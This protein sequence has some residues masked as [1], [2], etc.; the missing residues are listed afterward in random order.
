MTKPMMFA[1]CDL[2]PERWA[3]EAQ[4]SSRELEEPVSHGSDFRGV[5]V[6]AL[7]SVTASVVSAAMAGE[8]TGRD[9]MLGIVCLMARHCGRLVGARVASK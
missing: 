4:D 6:F 5:D 7:V 2:P 3:A 1:V 8:R 9:L